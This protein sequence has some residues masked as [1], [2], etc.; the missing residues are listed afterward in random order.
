MNFTMTNL[1]THH[2]TSRSCDSFSTCFSNFE[3]QTLVVARP[4][5]LWQ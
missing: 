1:P 2:S 3:V 5:F 4:H